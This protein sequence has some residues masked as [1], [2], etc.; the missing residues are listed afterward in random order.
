MFF[1]P[2]NYIIAVFLGRC[3]EAKR[4]KQKEIVLISCALFFIL[5]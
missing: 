2:L 5:Y 1:R 3:S 4:V